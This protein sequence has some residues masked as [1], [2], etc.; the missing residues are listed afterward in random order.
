M[1]PVSINGRWTLNLPE[2]R[3]TQWAAPWEVERIDSMHRHLTGR[4]VIYDIGAEEGDLP[5]LWASWGCRVAMFEPDPRVWPNI[6]ACFDANY[7]TGQVVGAFVGFAGT[8]DRRPHMDRWEL[9]TRWPKCS[10]G[11]IVDDHGFCNLSERPDIPSVRID[12]VVKQI[13]IPTALT[14]DVEGAELAVLE[15]AS[16]TL[17][18]FHPTVWVSVHPEFMAAMYGTNPGQ[19]H[20][21]MESHG[22]VGTLLATDHEQHWMFR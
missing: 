1:V 3:Q 7:L 18:A 6:R 19:I 8:I 10:T 21:L 11:P 5:A 13:P 9:A 12:T 4:D 16:E 17:G 14:I 2:H 15:G 20:D 22:Y